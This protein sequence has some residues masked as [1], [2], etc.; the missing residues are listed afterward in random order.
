MRDLKDRV[1]P[2][3]Q[4]N[5]FSQKDLTEEMRDNQLEKRQIRS[6]ILSKLHELKHCVRKGNR[7]FKMPPEMNQ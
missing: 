1:W 4:T 3:H 6:Q 2:T 5:G 7:F